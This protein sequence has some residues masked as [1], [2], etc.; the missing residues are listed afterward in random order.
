[1][2]IS[3]VDESGEPIDWWFA[4]KVPRLAK[5]S[6]AP[7]ATGYEYIYYDPRVGDV[8]KSPN[9]LT[10][11]S[12]ALDLTL[13]G[14]FDSPKETTGWILY[15]DEMPAD[16]NRHDSG[17]FGH[18][19]G[20]IAFDTASKTALW[21]LHSWP[22]F[23][24]PRASD[25]PTPIYGQTFI[26]LSM[27]M[28]TASR[29]ANQMMNHQEPQVYLPRIPN[30]LSKDDPLYLISQKV[31]P[32]ALAAADVIDCETRGGLPFKVIA[33]NRKWGEDFWID[34]VGPT[35]KSDMDV[36]TWIR[37]K[38]P[39]TLDNDGIHKTFDVKY[40]DLSP[41]GIPWAW[42]E[43]HDHAK[44]GLTVDS[45]WVCVGDINRMIS[46]EKRGGGTIALQD[47]KLWAA[48]SKTD[49][50]VAPPGHSRVDAH[51]LIKETHRTTHERLPG[52]G[53]KSSS[54]KSA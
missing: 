2:I 26:C 38:I 30:S 14:L 39:P 50:M 29:I 54:A 9:L 5:E 28:A 43:T 18:T 25:M 32:N 47:E 42:P 44:W 4:Y 35:L 33:K 21:L 6:N 3:P 34:L 11:G 20:V 19:K 12:G 48:L 23:A 45:D 37:G 15:N 22:K 8:T 7:S 17:R 49:L 16:A 53:K 46:Q 1:M 27:D 31:N 36:E 40:I 51:G 52:G 24:D 41:L 10:D 13:N